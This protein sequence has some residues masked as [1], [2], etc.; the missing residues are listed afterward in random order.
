[1]TDHEP[2]ADERRAQLPGLGYADKFA[3]GDQTSDTE[4]SEPQDAP[5]ESADDVPADD[6]STAST[7]EEGQAGASA[8]PPASQPWNLG[9]GGL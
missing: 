7:P 2:T 1:M 4:E 5:D 8:P 6:D 9:T 3:H